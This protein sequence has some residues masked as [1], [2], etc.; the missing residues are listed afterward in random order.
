MNPVTN[1][2]LIVSLLLALAAGGN[3][4]KGEAEAS[5]PSAS[6]ITSSGRAVAGC[7]SWACTSNHNETLVRDTSPVQTD[8]KP[9]APKKVRALKDINDDATKDLRGIVKKVETK[10]AKAKKPESRR[11]RITLPNKGVDSKDRIQN[12]EIQRLHQ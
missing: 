8:G 11:S 1:L 4:S 12:G 9:R 10:A 6:R 3:S 5:S 7:S 2:M